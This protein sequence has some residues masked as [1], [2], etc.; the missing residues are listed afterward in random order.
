GESLQYMKD[1]DAEAMV[2]YLRAISDVKPDPQPV[3][4]ERT[5]DRLDA[6][7]DPT[8]A[9]LKS[10]ENLSDGELLYL[11]NCNACHMPDGRGA[12]G[13]FPA[14]KGNSLVTAPTTKGLTEVILHGATLPSTAERPERLE[15]PAF[16]DRLS[17]ADIATLATFLRSAW[18]NSAPAVTEDDVKAVR[19]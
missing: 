4:D 10:A 14:L 6:A 17:D 18:G 9:K 3:P 15:M 7:D 2:A 13:V 19:Q 16:G 1:E 12:P 5:A 11:N 8:T